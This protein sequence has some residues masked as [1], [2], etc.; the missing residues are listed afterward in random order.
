MLGSSRF[1]RRLDPNSQRGGR[2]EQLRETRDRDRW[3]E[4]MYALR[5]PPRA[6]TPWEKGL[7]MAKVLDAVRAR[8]TVGEIIW[9]PREVWGECTEPGII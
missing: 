8:A 3:Q 7:L 9:A 5:G 4:A 6:R 2:L 1:G